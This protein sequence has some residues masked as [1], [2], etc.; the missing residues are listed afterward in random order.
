MLVEAIKCFDHAGLR[1]RNSQ[2]SVSELTAK[3]LVKARLVRIIDQ[4]PKVAAGKKSSAL[5]VVQVSP[6][7]TVKESGS[8]ATRRRKSAALSSQTPLIE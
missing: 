2:F 6:Q 3:E 5:P 4:R 7:T 8:G 1:V